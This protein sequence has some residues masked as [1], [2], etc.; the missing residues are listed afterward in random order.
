MSA[1]LVEACDGLVMVRFSGKLKVAELQAVQKAAGDAISRNGKV[2]V[3]CLA[4]DF[5]GWEKSEDWGDVSFQAEY[6]PF[7]E[8]IAIVGDRK[9]E[10][11]A[12]LFTS[13]GIRRVPI[14]YFAPRELGKAYQWLGALPKSS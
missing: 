10:E 7:I 6:D 14:E 9:W 13:K 1:E 5:D 4:E 12:L 3:L 2:R 8:K 11:L